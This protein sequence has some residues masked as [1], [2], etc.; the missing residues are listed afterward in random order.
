MGK[1]D[2]SKDCTALYKYYTHRRHQ[3]ILPSC[4]FQKSFK[5]VA[6][7]CINT[8]MLNNRASL[9]LLIVVESNKIELIQDK[10]QLHT[11]FF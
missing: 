6:L 3:F 10:H 8:C 4:S 1:K 9:P 11:K 5:I 7:I 2:M